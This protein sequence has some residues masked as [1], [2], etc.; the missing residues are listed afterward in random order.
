MHE[1]Y[2]NNDKDNL[3]VSEFYEYLL[4]RIRNG[5]RAVKFDQMMHMKMSI[6][7]MIEAGYPTRFIVSTI[8]VYKKYLKED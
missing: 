4:R 2:N 6:D 7:D 3:E 1:D 5:A 8:S